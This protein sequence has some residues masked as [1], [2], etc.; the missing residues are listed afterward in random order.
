MIVDSSALIAIFFR[1]PN[2][3]IY[4]ERLSAGS[5]ARMGAPNWLETAM[6][7]EGR[8]HDEAR[9][10]L[11]DFL[12]R[13]LITLVAFDAGHGRV[14]RDAFRRYGRGR[15]LAALNFGDCMA[16]AVASLANEPLLYKGDDFRQ[17][18]IASALDA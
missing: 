8:G 15:H 1:E 17:T 9:V 12:D 2:H 11:Q 18:D 4:T 10:R 5:N 6:V 14:A 16:Y 7:I 3:E 13:G